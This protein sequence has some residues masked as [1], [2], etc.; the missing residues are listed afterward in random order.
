MIYDLVAQCVQ[1]R[2]TPDNCAV[3]FINLQPRRL[4]GVE[5]FDQQTVIDINL[6]LA[7]A[8]RVFGV[9]VVLSTAEPKSF[10]GNGWPQIQAFFPNE[11]AIGLSS[12]TSS[13]DQ[14]FVDAIKSAGRR[15]V[16]ISGVWNETCAV[17]PI[18]LT[19]HGVFEIYVVEDCCGDISQLA[20]HNA[21]R[22]LVLAGAQPVTALSVML[23]W[24]R[25]TGR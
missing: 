5:S 19:L 4:F 15:K 7:K 18:I 10:A 16:L 20:R 12:M 13:N 24:Q 22:R 8:A 1:S 14:Y 6:L 17:L 23:D 9:P 2:L 3:A 25:W 11:A 21:M